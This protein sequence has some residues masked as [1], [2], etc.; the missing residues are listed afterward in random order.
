MM[1]RERDKL[2]K[3]LGGI[4]DMGGVPD[5]IFVIDTN[6]E[7]LAIKEAKRLGIPV[8]AIVD[9]NCDP[10]G[11]TYPIP[12]NDDA[13]RAILLYCDLAA[14]AAIDGISRSQGSLGIDLGDAGMGSSV[15]V[16]RGTSSVDKESDSRCECA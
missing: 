11:I 9:T 8:A 12:G 2:E 16:G 14:R 15:S 10:D 7:Q 13:S 5:L 1:G 6:K 4:K 3:A